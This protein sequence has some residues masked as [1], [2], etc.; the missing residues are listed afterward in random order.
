MLTAPIRTALSL[1]APPALSLSKPPLKQGRDKP[2]DVPHR[3]YVLVGETRRT[4]AKKSRNKIICCKADYQALGFWLDL[5]VGAGVCL[6][7]LFPGLGDAEAGDQRPPDPGQPWGGGAATGSGD[8][9]AALSQSEKEKAA[10]K[11]PF[12]INKWRIWLLIDAAVK[13]VLIPTSRYFFFV[14]V[15]VPLRF[16]HLI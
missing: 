1:Q 11:S 6:P 9:G 10:L 2:G 16:L 5:Q 14:R 7:P 15:C 8:G 13:R 3:A 4:K 12:I